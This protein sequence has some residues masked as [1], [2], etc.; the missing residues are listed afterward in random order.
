MPLDFTSCYYQSSLLSFTSIAQIFQSGQS[1]H[2]SAEVSFYTYDRACVCVLIDGLN[3]RIRHSIPW[4]IA[5]YTPSR[6]REKHS[7]A[8]RVHPTLLSCSRHFLACFITEQST[9]LAFLFV[10]E[11]IQL[12]IVKNQHPALIR[13]LRLEPKNEEQ[14]KTLSL[15][16]F[17]SRFPL[18]IG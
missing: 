11:R 15:G 4:A 6:S 3:C 8:A 2:C 7:P 1:Q 16:Q 10:K 14:F 5:K 12:V 9:V 18:S 17:S 13:G